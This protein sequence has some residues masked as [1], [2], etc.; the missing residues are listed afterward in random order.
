MY[1]FHIVSVLVTSLEF[2]IFSVTL[3]YFSFKEA[4]QMPFT[5]ISRNILCEDL[6]PLFPL[7]SPPKASSP[8][9]I[10][11]SVS[12]YEVLVPRMNTFTS[13]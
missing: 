7:P 1:L 9:R 13:F 3:L 6:L 12:Y 2:L 5:T 8:M 4:F 10:P 11:T